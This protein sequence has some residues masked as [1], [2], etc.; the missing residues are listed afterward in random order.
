MTARKK[1]LRKKK[2]PARKTRSTR[3]PIATLPRKYDTYFQR[4]FGTRRSNSQLRILCCGSADGIST[5]DA[6]IGNDFADLTQSL[7]DAGR[8]HDDFKAT[9]QEIATIRSWPPSQLRLFRMALIEI[10]GPVGC[11][12]PVKKAR[13]RGR[14]GASEKSLNVAHGKQIVITFRGA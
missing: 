13:F 14:T 4:N 1:V 6:Q 10:F 9:R 3:S 8:K 7:S 2:R 12:R 5:D 11:G